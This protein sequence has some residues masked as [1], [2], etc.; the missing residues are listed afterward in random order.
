[1]IQSKIDALLS[2]LAATLLLL[3]SGPSRGQAVRVVKTGAGFHLTRAGQPYFIKG[4]GG[5][6]SKTLLHDCGGNSVR[7]WGA[8]NLEP[9]LAEA[10]K[11]GLTVTIGLWLGQKQQGFDYHNAA[12]VAAQYETA[13]RTILRYRDSPALLVWAFGNEMEVG[14]EDDAAMWQAIEA[15]AALAKKLDPNHPT[16]TVVAELGGDK[17]SQLNR[18]CPDIDIVGINSY[19]GA[20][21]VAARYK[22]A[23]GVKPF[24]ITEFGPPGPWELPKNTWGAALE[25]TS[26]QKADWYRNAYEKSIAKQP[27][28][29]GSYAFQWGHKQEATATWFG[30]LLPDGSRLAPVD[31]LREL[32]TG[33]VPADP[34]PVI[35]S[36]TLAGPDRVAAGATVHADLKASDAANKRLKVT[37]VLQSDPAA[38]HTG[39]AAE[40]APATFTAAIQKADETHADV[41]IPP[42]AGAYRL[43]AYVS[44]GHG[45]AAVANIPLFATGG[46]PPTTPGRKAS[47]PLTLYGQGAP[48]DLPF[49]PSGYMGNTGAIQMDSN[50]PDLPH[51][52]KAC[53]KATYTAD[54]D[55]GGVV[56]QSPADDWGSLPGG[57]DLTGAKSLTFWARG[58]RGGEVVAFQFGLL[59]KDKTFSDTGTGKL[60]GV[61]L[62]TA[63]KRYTIDL[64]GQDLSRIKTGFCWTVAAPG[65]PVT[66]YLDDIR[67]E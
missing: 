14:D 59:G 60:G 43:F 36:L 63:W 37:W 57:W 19:A 27:L 45:G 38:Y 65:H 17:I 9:T 55:W 34:C 48:S 23:G 12:L 8:D 31:T 62:T 7:T 5:D 20:S 4:A 49:T 54:G 53:L 61:T 42:V 24:V 50:C 15:I 64:K 29:L 13:R 67:Y 22:V 39:G 25:P 56:W 35:H 44:D 18:F 33:K 47:L 26:T 3:A 58:G 52:G 6:A 40:G 16:M 10:Q 21:S 1:M 32:W 30:M 2:A 28:C 11:L 41:Q 46:V 66:F 51:S